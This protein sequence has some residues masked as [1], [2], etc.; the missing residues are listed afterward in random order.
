VSHLKTRVTA[1][2]AALLLLIVAP[3][4]AAA[5]EVNDAGDLPTTAQDLSAESVD[6][7]DGRLATAGDIDMY[8]LC[9]SGGGSFSA[10]TVGGTL[11]DT[12]LFL[13]DADGR[14][15]YANDDDGGILQSRLPSGGPLT[16]QVQGDYFLAVGAYNIDPLSASGSIFPQETGVVDPRGPGGGDPVTMWGGRASAGGRY[17]IFLTGAECLPDDTT[18]PTVDLRSPADGL[19]VNVG[20]PVKVEFS[21]DDEGG[22]GLASCI[23]TAPNDSMLDTSVPGLIGVTVTA[24]DNAGNETSVTHTVNVVAPDTSAP[25]IELL[26][27]VDDAQYLLGEEVRAEYT[28]TEET[29]GSGL[30]A[31]DAPVASGEPVDTSSVGLHEFTVTA[32]DKAGNT[33][34]GTVHYRVVYDFVGFLWPVL[35]PPQSNTWRAGVPV[36]IRFELGGNH[37]L[38]V[39]EEGW[40]QVAVVGCDFTEEP[41]GGQPARHPRWFKELVFRKRK[42]RY[43]MFWRT[44]PRWA[45]TCRQ[46][47]LKLK[48]GT[49]KRANFEFVGHP[50]DDDDDEDDDD[51]EKG[52]D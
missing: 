23:G 43:L 33:S 50:R 19:E 20:D 40:P 35:N 15:V 41:E 39:I 5:P 27:P 17:T 25:A 34:S 30:S 37:G 3:G 12:Q 49:V 45:G 51:K 47:M 32:R 28:C 31:C 10:S 1:A 24:R 22:S 44:D 6:R 13:F 21:C 42:Q 29:E 52:G 18:P 14:G 36:P 38:D 9:V 8:R 48:D 46:F 4:A 26:S 7:I 16:P 2:L 11:V